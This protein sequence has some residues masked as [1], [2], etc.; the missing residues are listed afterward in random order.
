MK[1][2]TIGWQVLTSK[3]NRGKKFFY[4][5]KIRTFTTVFLKENGEAGN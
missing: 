3:K 4:C 1:N 2:I 5:K